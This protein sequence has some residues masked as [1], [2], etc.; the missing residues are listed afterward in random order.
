MIC[1]NQAIKLLADNVTL[2]KAEALP[3]KHCLGRVLAEDVISR[4]SHPP[5]DVSSM[6][7]YAI[8][9]AD[10]AK[11]PVI[12]NLIGESQA[13]SRFDQTIQTGE[14][15]RVFTGA[16]LPKGAD[17]VE[18]QEN[19]REHGEGIEINNSVS[20]NTF[21]RTA[22]MDF[23]AGDVMIKTGT[24]LNAR[25][26]GLAA[27]MN[28][29]TLSVRKKPQVAILATGNEVTLPGADI[30]PSQIITS[31][32]FALHAY[33]IAMG[34]EPIDLGIAGDTLE[35]LD[36]S[37]EK[38]IPSDILVTIGGISVG[39]Y[40]LVKQALSK[41]GLKQIFHKVAMRPGK[42]TLF[43]K[44]DNLSILCMPGNPVSAGVCSILFLKKALFTMLGIKTNNEPAQTAILGVD[45][46]EN[47]LRQD[48]VRARLKIN[49]A[50]ERIALP[51]SKQDSAMLAHFTEADCLI[52]RS[53]HAPLTRAGEHV[54]ILLFSGSL[55]SL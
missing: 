24:V 12:L 7:G 25:H 36:S 14:T 54:K 19:A 34:G 37:I 28:Q 4:V 38:A 5:V 30:A 20:A 39:D 40:D 52:I 9:A 47:D 50:G 51:F 15:V 44:I 11:P 43:G 35:E 13:G 32:S 10:T 29:S 49:E 18:M 16:P 31:N 22:G 45:M 6:D 55:I 27:A 21:V 48:Y 26:V 17:A 23:N 42:P 53:P 8:K 33:V 2:T 1:V 46:V 41:K 3:L